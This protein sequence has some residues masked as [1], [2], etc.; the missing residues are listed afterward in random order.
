MS[1]AKE[2]L[3]EFEALRALS[4]LLLFALHSE[5]LDPQI[6]GETIGGALA[7]Y[8]ASFLLGS[9]FF[10][11]G[12]F[13]E[14]SLRKPASSA[15]TFVWSK[16]IRIFPP[17]WLALLLFIFVMGYTLNRTGLMVYALNLQ[18]VFSPAFVKQ[19][20]TL[21]YISMLV[22]FYILYGFLMVNIRS[23][24]GLLLGALLVFAAAYGAHITVGL[25]D[26][27]F[28]QYYFL[29]LA[30]VY[31]CRF[32]AVREF[33]FS[34]NGF[35][36]IILAILSIWLFGLVLQAGYGMT[37]GIY[38]LAVDIFVLSWVLLSLAVFRTKVGDW[39]GW[40]WISTA[41]FFAYLYHRPLWQ[42]LDT[43]FGLEP[44]LEKVL[45]H[46]VPGAILALIVG[47][48]L[49]RGYDLLL[50]GLRLK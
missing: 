48:V 36:K 8:V 7:V 25:F 31:F 12:Y 40:A 22:V 45:V 4:I 10:L 16:F 50:A 42:A 5:V 26:L 43:I 34:L 46:L 13:T 9:F 15:L 38:I 30:G 17:Y 29:F 28:F 49:Q 19:L 47:Y 2:R 6:F 24:W 32:E 44:G 3:K 41:S 11:A 21:W 37:H 35:V 27:R 23:S 39:Q 14:V 33:L 18:A 20:L 1:Q